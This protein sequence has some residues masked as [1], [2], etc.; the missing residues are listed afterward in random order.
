MRY[1]FMKQ[2]NTFDKKE[3]RLTFLCMT[4]KFSVPGMQ[5]FYIKLYAIH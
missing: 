1:D 2:T 5:L 3:Q 4:T